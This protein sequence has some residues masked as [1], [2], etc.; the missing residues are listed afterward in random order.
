[1]M[2]HM[3]KARPFYAAATVEQ[4]VD[5]VEFARLLRH[6]PEAL[7][8]AVQCARIFCVDVAGERRYPTF[9]ADDSYRRRDLHQV[10]RRLGGLPGGS[11]LQF[12]IRPKASLGGITPL[13][14]LRRGALANVLRAA[15]GFAER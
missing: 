13:E 6:R 10:S 12:F 4:L 15:D 2:R 3:A 9:F 7:I 14:A 8:E 11:K 1:M 5:E